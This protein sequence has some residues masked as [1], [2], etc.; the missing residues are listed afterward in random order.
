MSR[1]GRIQSPARPL[2]FDQ[3]T[4]KL[5]VSRPQTLQSAEV[6]HPESARCP[7][8]P[9]TRDSSSPAAPFQLSRPTIG[10]YVT[11]LESLFLLER[12]PPWHSNRLSRLVETPKLH[13]GDTGVAAALLNLGPAQ[14][15]ADRP[16]LGQLLASWQ[17]VPVEFSHF[18]D[19]DGV[20]VDIVMEQGSH[21]VAGVEVKA[22]ATVRRGD[23]QGLRKLRGAAGDRFRQG[24]VLY[25]GETTVPFGDGLYAVPMA[26]LWE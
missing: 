9:S 8:R 15:A 16:L 13:L 5:A 7:N 3:P 26:R 18:R 10:E 19:R 2:P 17:E 1:L 14:L 20:E 12:L 6:A 4:R 25:D 24:V 22:S 11:L 21:A 23:F